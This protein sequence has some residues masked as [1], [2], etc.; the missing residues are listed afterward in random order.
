MTA[1]IFLC[2][3]LFERSQNLVSDRYGVREALQSRCELLK[4]V[5]AE[6]AVRDPGG[7][8]QV[9]VLNRHIVAIGVAH[10]NTLAIFVDASDRPHDHGCVFLLA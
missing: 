2:L 10:E 3:R 9:V 1:R 5:V 4:F 8:N 7:E 6:V